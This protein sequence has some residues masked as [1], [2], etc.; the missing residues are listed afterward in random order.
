MHITLANPYNKEKPVEQNYYDA[1]SENSFSKQ[2]NGS[3]ISDYLDGKPA[4]IGKKKITRKQR[5]EWFWTSDFVS[6]LDHET[7]TGDE[8]VLALSRYF[9]QQVTPNKQLLLHL[10]KAAPDT[11]VTAVRYS[12][13]VA[14]KNNTKLEELQGIAESSDEIAELCKIIEILQEAHQTRIEA[15]EQAKKKLAHLTVIDFLCY[16]ALYAFKE[17][18]PVYSGQQQIIDNETGHPIE[19]MSFAQETEVALGDLLTW[20]VQTCNSQHLK[21]TE[22]ELAKSVGSHISP[23]LFDDGSMGQPDWQTLHDFELLVGHQYELNDFV[24]RSLNAF[25]YDNSICYARN[26]HILEIKILDEQQKQNWHRNGRKLELLAGYWYIKGEQR[27]ILSGLAD[28]VIGQPENSEYNKLA[29]AKALSGT[30]FLRNIY[31]VDEFISLEGVDKEVDTFQLLLALELNSVFFNTCYFYPYFEY[32]QSSGSWQK[33]LHDLALD[34][35]LEGENRFP[36]TWAYKKDKIARTREWTV[37]EKHP[38]GSAKTAEQIIDFC[39]MDMAALKK[40]LKAEPNA[41]TANLS[42]KPYLKFGNI[43]FQLPWI[44][45]ASNNR[46]LVVNNLR[47]LGAR[48]KGAQ[49]EASRL[50]T[51]WAGHF[52]KK[53]FSVVSNWHPPATEHANPGEIDLICARDNVVFVFEIKSGYIRKSKQQTW[54]HKTNTLRRAGKQLQVKHQTVLEHL[55]K[56]EELFEKLGL[57]E[58]FCESQVHGWI[59]DTSIEH[60]HELFNGFLK[61]SIEEIYIALYDQADFL[62]GLNDSELSHWMKNNMLKETTL[63]PDG[64]SAQEFYLAITQERVWHNKI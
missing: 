8:F 52:E 50:E 56:K 45:A 63:Y 40:K 48:R 22:R 4:R 54:L 34:G 41:P 2:L 49:E 59:L 7:Y 5:D 37:S 33:A 6:R 10:A 3:L 30:L 46:T 64:F 17:I 53:G 42:E 55:A 19:P 60:D 39:S 18:I 1:R 57:D 9:G 36:I 61:V 26:G 28:I 14:Q 16:A 23:F 43:L 20:K 47:R 51:I 35:L 12:G 13:I 31:G 38:S 32:L 58:S 25:S 24:S 21:I 11:I 29:Y 15:L 62:V 44:S 27:L